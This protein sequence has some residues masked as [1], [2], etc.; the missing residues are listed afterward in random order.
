MKQKQNELFFSGFNRGSLHGAFILDI[1]FNSE[2]L[3]KHSL[4]YNCNEKLKSDHI[5][6]NIK[7][8]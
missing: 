5:F 1:K 6:I 8:K 3:Q 2:R 4:A 7:G